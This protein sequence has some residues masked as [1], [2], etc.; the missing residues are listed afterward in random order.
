MGAGDMTL[1]LGGAA[2]LKLLANRGTGDE[3]RHCLSPTACL[4]GSRGGTEGTCAEN[5]VDFLL[6]VSSCLMGVSE[7]AFGKGEGLRYFL[8]LNTWLFLRVGLGPCGSDCPE[9]SVEVWSILCD[10]SICSRASQQFPKSIL[11]REDVIILIISKKE[12]GPFTVTNKSRRG[13]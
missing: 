10:D 11:L 1:F 9:Q 4:E 6:R 12:E 8:K 2:G 3:D 5:K 7:P 13:H